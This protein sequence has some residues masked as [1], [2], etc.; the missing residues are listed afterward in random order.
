MSTVTAIDYRRS[1]LRKNVLENPYWITSSEVIGVDSE[2]KAAILFS[3]PHVDR[4]TMVHEVIIQV[5]QGFTV[6]A[7]AALCTVGIGS[8]ATDDIT[9]GGVV[10]DVDQDS[11]ILTASITVATAGYYPPIS[12]STSTWLTSQKGGTITLLGSQ[13]IVGAATAV[14]VICAYMSN[15]GG[16]ITA[17]RIRAHFMISELPGK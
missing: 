11:Y 4:V 5:T 3:F 17:G 2:D 13:F 16:A 10:T 12:A 8:L 7:G 9:T 14:P 1:D 6:G 15:A